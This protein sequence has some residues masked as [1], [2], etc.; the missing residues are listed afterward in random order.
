MFLCVCFRLL[1]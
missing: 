1:Q